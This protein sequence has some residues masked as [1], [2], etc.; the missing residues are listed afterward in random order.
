ML[1]S[2]VRGHKELFSQG[3]CVSTVLGHDEVADVR[4]DVQR[5]GACA[6]VDG[7]RPRLCKRFSGAL[8]RNRIAAQQLRPQRRHRLRVDVQAERCHAVVDE[9]H[10][11]ATK[12]EEVLRAHRLLATKTTVLSCGCDPFQR[13]VCC[14]RGEAV[15]RAVAHGRQSHALL[16]LLGWRCART[17][18]CPSGACAS[19]LA[20]IG[21]CSNTAA[22]GFLS[23]R[24]GFQ[25]GTWVSPVPLRPR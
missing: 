2:T 3:R 24:S 17:L 19:T 8:L 18:A 12:H 15:R 13:Y 6:R 25:A 20:S 9:A 1:R 11:S 21:S 23:R 10:G 22:D 7:D 4:H 14:Q 5:S 16:D